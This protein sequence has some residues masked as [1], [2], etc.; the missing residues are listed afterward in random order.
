MNPLLQSLL[1]FPLAKDGRGR[2]F[3][4]PPQDS[5][6]AAEHD[7]AFYFVF[8]VCFFFFFLIVIWLAA[9]LWRY[10]ERK[11]HVERDTPHHNLPLE[12]VWSVIPL[13]ITIYMFWIGFRGMMNQYNPPGDGLNVIV[14][15]QQW[16]WSFTYPDG[17]QSGGEDG[18]HVP[19]GENVILTMT[20]SDVLHSLFVPNFR[21]KKDVV[22]GRFHK[23]WF[24]ATKLGEHHL[25]C[26]EYCGTKHSTMVSKVVVED[27]PTYEAWLKKAGDINNQLS[28]KDAGEKWYKI[29]G[30]G[31]CHSLD[32]S[33][34]TGPTWKDVWGKTETL[35]DG[36]TVTVNDE[37]ILES[38]VNPGAKVVQGFSNVMPSFQ[39]RLDDRS[40][41]NISAYIKSLSSSITPEELEEISKKPEPKEGAAAE[42]GATPGTGTA[43]DSTPASEGQAGTTGG[44]S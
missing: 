28:P 33:R 2:T 6:V 11:G 39:G 7:F 23:I 1:S 34:L 14:Q 16:N 42:P 27:R 9:F 31:Q 22:P 38:I 32:G 19:L 21:I 30:C 25:F 5:T 29:Q 10:R 36:S 40:I 15:A 20:S 43:T 8:W 18:M 26:T 24:N 44:G 13:L 3:W 37:Y 41:L 35:S 17:T 12:V 4:L